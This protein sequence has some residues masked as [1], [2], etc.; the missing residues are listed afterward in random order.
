MRALFREAFDRGSSEVAAAPPVPPEP[1]AAIAPAPA[2][3][4]P[5]APATPASPIPVVAAD[6]APLP[7]LGGERLPAC[8]EPWKSLYI[9]RRGVLPCCYGGRPI[10]PMEDYKAAWNGP[11]MQAIRGELVAARFHDYCLASP[12]CPIVR[13]SAEAGAMP[14]GQRFLLSARQRWAAV[15]RRLGGL[16]GRIWRPLKRGA[17][18][19]RVLVT[20]PRRVARAVA[21][22]LHV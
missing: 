13:K 2:A 14:F 4:A 17:Q 6:A 19:V 16:P 12:S 3:S 9:L 8:L 5:V 15:D 21:R 1:A 11:L 7:S 22:R 10:A 18:G 20:D